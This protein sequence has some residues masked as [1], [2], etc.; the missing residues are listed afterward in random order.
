MLYL[1]TIFSLLLPALAINA[2]S[3]SNV[4]VYWGQNSGGSQQRLS[5][6]CDSDAVDIVI[7][8]FMHQFPSP[9]QLN[10]A[11]ACEGTYTA[12]GI[13][14]C[15]TI[16]EDIK[17]CQNKGKTI[18]LSLGGAAGSYGF[19]DDATAKQFAHTLWDLFG[20][21][22][23]LATNDRPFY[24]AVLDG[25]DFDIENNWSTG[26]PALATEL[27]TL[28]QKDTSKNYYLGAAP[29]CPYPDASVGPLLKQSEIDFVFIQ[30]YNNY[31]N[32]GSSSFNWDTW[33]NYAET[34]SPNKNI[35]L[36]VGVPASSRAA[37]SGYNDPSAVSQYLTSD[38]LN[39]KYFGGI[40]MWDVSAGWSNTNSNG[41]FV[42]N[43]KA[44]VKKASPGEETTSSSTT[45]TTT[46]TSTTISSSSS[47]SKTSKTSTTSTTSSS[48]SSTTSSTTSSTS[49]S[50]TSSSTSSTT[51]SST[52]SSQISTTST[53]PTSSTSLSSSTISTSASTSDTT[54][55]TSSETTP[56]VTPSSLSSAITIPG[57]ST[58]TGISKSSSTKPATSTT[59]ALSSSTTTVATIPDDK[60]I[61]NTPTDTETTSKPPAIITESDATTITQNL[62]P[63]TTTKNVKTTS[64]NIVTEWVWAPTTLRT[65]TTTYQ[66]LTTRT[67]IETVFA[68]PSTVVIYN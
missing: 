64:T 45:T 54:S 1:L 63:S 50:S 7:L 21:S 62:T 61:I 38:I 33:L 10:F 6:Y 35:K 30:F 22:K 25:F 23:N 34:D 59:S 24:D 37:G 16:A 13:L 27:R 4:A 28:F 55:V 48:I 18:L 44:I 5:Y 52:T 26:Y 39:S 19:S 66:I 36:F 9:I 58:T 51:S 46:T 8:S 42:E 65:L 60:E 68:E 20:N 53:A 41:N 49:S 67:H 11:N 31:C 32:L 14:Q 43:M 12:N 3:N 2:R 40:S 17:Y 47:S 15:Q 56:V 57:D 29:Q